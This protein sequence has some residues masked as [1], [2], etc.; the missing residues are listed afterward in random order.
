MDYLKILRIYLHIYY[1]NNL[2]DSLQ[3]EKTFRELTIGLKNEFILIVSG[4]TFSLIHAERFILA[5]T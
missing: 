1:N 5:M 4:R 2:G 3:K